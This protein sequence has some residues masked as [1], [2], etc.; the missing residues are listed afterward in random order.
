MKVPTPLLATALFVGRC[1]VGL[2]ASSVVRSLHH[3]Y[4]AVVAFVNSRF[5]KLSEYSSSA[6]VSGDGGPHSSPHCPLRRSLHRRS[7]CI[8]GRSVVGRSSLHSVAFVN[9]QFAKLSKQSSSA[10]VSGDG[11]PRSSPCHCTLR[12]PLHVLW[13][14]SRAKVGG[15]GFTTSLFC[16]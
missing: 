5:A 9:S 2:V 11:G 12:P 3:R 13:F 10:S 14:G 4:C 8:V 6:S 15:V 7:R 16:I 1:I